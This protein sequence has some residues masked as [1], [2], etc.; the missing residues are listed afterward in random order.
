MI[1]SDSEIRENFNV[2][3]NERGGD[4]N[5]KDDTSPSKPARVIHGVHVVKCASCN[6]E[7]N[8]NMYFMVFDYSYPSECVDNVFNCAF[9]ALR[10][11]GVMSDNDHFVILLNGNL[12]HGTPNDTIKLWVYH[13]ESGKKHRFLVP[14]LKSA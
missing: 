11:D 13:A 2:G 6:K 10:R 3:S 14:D 4:G 7:H 5:N 1:G 12:G 9:S 8:F